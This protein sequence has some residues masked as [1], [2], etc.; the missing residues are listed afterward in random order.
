MLTGLLSWNA[1]WEMWGFYNNPD[2]A[3]N[4]KVVFDGY[5]RTI[6]ILQGI[7]DIVVREDLYSTWKEWMLVSDNQKWL[8]AFLV[9]GAT[10]ISDTR[11]TGIT[12]F[13]VND[14]TIR[15]QSGGI[16]TN[17]DGN[18]YGYYDE[19]VTP[20]YPYLPDEGGLISISSTVSNLV[21]LQ[22]VTQEKPAL[23]MTPEQEWILKLAYEEARRS[24]AMQTNT[25]GITTVNDIDT[26]TVYDDDGTTPLYEIRVSG[27]NCDNRLVTYSKDTTEINGRNV[28]CPLPEITEDPCP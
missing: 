24:R 25:V 15:Q 26:I 18:L 9:E 16:P 4:F 10:P 21:D 20:K 6:W 2:P 28:Y 19:A 14:W 8:H 3:D 11:A 1:E 17:I 7:Q 22:I 5:T 23:G 13:L 27:E 12:Y